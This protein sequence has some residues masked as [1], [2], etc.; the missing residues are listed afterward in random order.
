M[1]APLD[2][3]IES[4]RLRLVPAAEAYAE[5][6]LLEFTAEITTYMFPKPPDAIEEVLAFI[7]RSRS[8]MARSEALVVAVLDKR[9]GEFLGHGG[10]HHIDSDTPEL[11]IWLKK[12]A[13]GHRYG[14]EAVTALAGWAQHNLP[15]RYLIYPVDRRNVASRKIP[16]SLGGVIEAEYEQTGAGGQALS[17]LEYRMYAVAR[18]DA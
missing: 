15:F 8:E 9:T 17:L 18:P 1:L 3:V 11:G 12:G 13:H 5:S 6:I 16:E 14:R 7:A 10:L 2:T 4:E